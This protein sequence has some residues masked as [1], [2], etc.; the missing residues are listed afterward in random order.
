MLEYRGNEGEIMAPV[1]ID[2]AIENAAVSSG[3][4]G[5]IIDDNMKSLIKKVIEGKITMEEAFSLINNNK[6]GD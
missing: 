3:M 6:N 1:T 4:E 5:I 2:R